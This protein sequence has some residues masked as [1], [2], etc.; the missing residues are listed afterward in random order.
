[1]DFL[2]LDSRSAAENPNRMTILQQADGGPILDGKKP[3]VVLVKGASSRTAQAAMREEEAARMKKA[4]KSKSEMVDLQKQLSEAAA[5]F[6]IGFEGVQRPDPD[7]GK[8]RDL[9]NS[10]DDLAWFFDL[11]AI[12]LPHLMRGDGS[13][14]TR[15]EDETEAAFETRFESEMGKWLKPS[16][17]QQVIDCAREDDNFLVQAENG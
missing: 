9:T 16:F 13:S 14:I 2:K 7:T 8:L 6:V 15:N 12:S 3:C 1:M 17:S 10:A 5:R 11:N 4:K